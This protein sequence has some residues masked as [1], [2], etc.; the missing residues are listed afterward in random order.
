M[1]KALM[2]VMRRRGCMK[3]VKSIEDFRLTGVKLSPNRGAQ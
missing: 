1:T 3:V 2:I